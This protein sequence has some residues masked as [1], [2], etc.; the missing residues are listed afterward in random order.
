MLCDVVKAELYFGAY[1]SVRTDANLNLLETLFAAFDSFP[2]DGKAAR[3]FGEL[4]ADLSRK[5]TPIGP[6][7]MQI[8]AIALV[9][10]CI[11]VTH[12][13]TEFSRIAGLRVEDWEI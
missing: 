11:L 9:N 2:F 10:D 4:R 12:N 8:A 7:D 5:G 3:V 1:K 13:T 6:Y